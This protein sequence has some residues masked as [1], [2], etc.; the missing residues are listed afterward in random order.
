M[1]GKPFRSPLL[2]KKE[3]LASS[4]DHEPQAKKRRISGND[5]IRKEHAGPQLVFKAPGISSLPRKP[6]LTVQNP[7]KAAEVAK[8]QHAGIEGYYNVLWSVKSP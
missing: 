5:E 7:A 3:R 8:P 1:L 2:A 4:D 6:L